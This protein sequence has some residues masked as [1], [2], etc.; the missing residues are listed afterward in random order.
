MEGRGWRATSKIVEAIKEL[1]EANMVTCVSILDHGK[2]ATE[3]TGFE[4]WKEHGK[5]PGKLRAE[6]DETLD[7][8]E[9]SR[10]ATA[11]PKRK[12]KKRTVKRSLI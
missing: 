1:R 3:I 11:V 2:F 12:Y 10:L 5:V 8:D 7:S 6:E 9:S 4:G